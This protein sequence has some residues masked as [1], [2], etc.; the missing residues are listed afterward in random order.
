VTQIIQ[1]LSSR[2]NLEGSWT[3]QNRRIASPNLNNKKLGQRHYYIKIQAGRSNLAASLHA[4]YQVSP[5]KGKTGCAGRASTANKTPPAVDIAHRIS[6]ILNRWSLQTYREGIL[7][8]LGRF[9]PNPSEADQ[10]AENS[11]SRATHHGDEPMLI[12]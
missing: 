9:N 5:H 8:F 11:L 12:Y 4:P 3:T 7:T 2:K 1:I 6:K 10:E